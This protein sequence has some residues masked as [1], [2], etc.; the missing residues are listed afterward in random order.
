MQQANRSYDRDIYS[1]ICKADGLKAH[2][3]ADMLDI[4]RRLVN[5]ALYTSPLLRE[6]CYDDDEHCWYALIRQ[7]VPHEGLYDFCA[8]YGLAKEFA[9]LDEDAFL[10][11]MCEGCERVGRNLNDTRGLMHSFRDCR[12]NIRVLLRDMQDFIGNRWEN[13]ELVFELRI[14]RARFIRIY[15]DVLIVTEKHVFSLEF[16]MKDAPEPEEARQAVKYKPYLEIIFG[17]KYRVIPALVLTRA[18]ELFYETQMEDG[19]QL[20]ISSGDMLFNVLD[21]QMHF[22][23]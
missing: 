16:K 15:A 18:S 17:E 8:W 7:Q 21:T 12:E 10:R 9:A 22:L 2:K 6:L 4:D 19:T 20:Y 23:D 13:W 3:I 1:L 5:Q 14:N 11:E